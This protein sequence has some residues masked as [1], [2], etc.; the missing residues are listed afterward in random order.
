MRVFSPVGERNGILYKD[1]L[2]PRFADLKGKIIGF[3][4]NRAGK[5]YFERIEELLKDRSKVSQIKR[6]VKPE[7]T[8]PASLDLINEVACGC[9]VAVVGTGV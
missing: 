8:S 2:A 1:Q 6:W 9:D 4:D 5:A 3:L 7:Q